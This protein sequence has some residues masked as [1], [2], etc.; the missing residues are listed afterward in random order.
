MSELPAF[1][2]LLYTPSAY[3]SPDYSC[4]APRSPKDRLAHRLLGLLPSHTH[5]AA[6]ADKMAHSP[7]FF[8]LGPGPWSGHTFEAGQ[9]APG[10][11][12]V[13]HRIFHNTAVQHFESHGDHEKK[14]TQRSLVRACSSNSGAG[15]MRW[16]DDYLGS[17][18][19][20]RQIYSGR[21]ATKCLNPGSTCCTTVPC[22]SRLSQTQ[23]HI[24]QGSSIHTA[25]WCTNVHSLH[26]SLVPR[27]ILHAR[28]LPNGLD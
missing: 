1:L 23:A 5:P 4:F 10:S 28:N 12:V 22:S 15:T 24:H 2:P 11:A 16:V 27:L 21:K 13:S 9:H 7:P 8:D 14:L 17:S 20:E 26:R 6:T 3:T 19:K 25:T 18:L